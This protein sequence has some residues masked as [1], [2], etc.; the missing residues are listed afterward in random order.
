MC[1][2]TPRIRD[3][4]QRASCPKCSCQQV[5]REQLAALRELSLRQLGLTALKRGDLSGLTHLEVLDLTGNPLKALPD[6]LPSELGALKSMKLDL[7]LFTKLPDGVVT[8][9]LD[10]P[11]FSWEMA[12]PSGSCAAYELKEPQ[13]EPAL[14]LSE[15]EAVL[16]LS[17]SHGRIDIRAW[18]RGI[19]LV[20]VWTRT[21]DLDLFAV[22]KGPDQR[23][24]LLARAERP[25]VLSGDFLYGFDLAPYRLTPSERGFGLRRDASGGVPYQRLAEEEEL[26]IFRIREGKIERVL[27][28]VAY[29]RYI[30]SGSP[31]ALADA[32]DIDYAE[33]NY[34]EQT[35]SVIAVARSKTRGVFNWVKAQSNYTTKKQ[36][37][38]EKPGA[39]FS[40]VV[41]RWTGEHYEG[42]G[43]P[44]TSYFFNDE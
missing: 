10:R 31:P 22:S 17:P 9:L 7:S 20:G 18:T 27:R 12:Y 1:K 30:Q 23:L 37:A 32:E 25:V 11:G 5:T 24:S 44:T 14:P 43:E 34:E 35:C 33:W 8:P 42:S 6:S 16:Q 4:I 39:E 28:T 13:E 36:A 19:Y 2:R 26:Q 15:L 40:T 21:N 29:T 3:A 41:F 38:D